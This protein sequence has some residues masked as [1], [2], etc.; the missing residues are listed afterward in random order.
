M[1]KD[2]LDAECERRAESFCNCLKL[3]RGSAHDRQGN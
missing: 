2:N 3:Q 1:F